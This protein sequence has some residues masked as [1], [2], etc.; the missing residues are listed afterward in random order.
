MLT[1]NLLS[2]LNDPDFVKSSQILELY[3]LT[4]ESCL[5]KALCRKIHSAMKASAPQANLEMKQNFLFLYLDEFMFFLCCWCKKKER[6]KY[7]FLSFALRWVHMSKLASLKKKKKP[8]IKD[9]IKTFCIDSVTHW[10]SFTATS[11]W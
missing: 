1:N 9:F 5:N 8:F 7:Y 3:V 11:P 2:S 4:V 10:V 6:R